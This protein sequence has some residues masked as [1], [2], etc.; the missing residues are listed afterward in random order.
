MTHITRRQVLAALATAP[1]AVALSAASSPARASGSARRAAQVGRSARNFAPEP[2]DAIVTRWDRDPWSR[3]SYSALPVGASPAARRVLGQTVIGRRLA[4]AGEFTSADYP[5][6]TQGAY[7]S[8]RRAAKLLLRSVQPSSAIVIGAGLAGAAAAQALAAD[9][10][11]VT[12]I[13]ARDRIGGRL[14]TDSAWGAPVELGAAW[15]HGVR[16]NPIVP[17]AQASGLSLVPCDYEDDTIHAMQT[18]RYSPDAARQ[19]ARLETL[20]GALEEDGDVGLNLSV[21]AWL[22]QRGWSATAVNAW[23]EEVTIAQ[24]FGLD[25]TALSARALGEGAWLRGGDDLVAGGYQRIV[26]QLLDDLQVRLALPVRD[27]QVE[28]TGVL[29]NTSTERLRAEAVVIAVPLALLQAGLPTIT[30]LPRP[31]RTAVRS[32]TTGN[33]EKVI[34]RFAEQWWPNTRMLGVVDTENS[35]RGDP[36]TLRWTEFL[37]ITDVIG[38]PAIV[39]FAGGQAATSRPVDDTVCAAEAYAKLVS[40]FAGGAFSRST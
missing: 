39:A 3:G 38:T 29:V 40:G 23:A 17:L 11:R 5:A 34:L 20:L 37:S 15:I 12:V 26:A 8:G 24:E 1:T 30:P 27:V 16:G 19:L 13:E 14:A 10:V 35:S 22:R 21:Q 6:T 33:L 32:L 9:G 25:A 31:V 18:H 28:S 36:A 2:L 7:L 4:F